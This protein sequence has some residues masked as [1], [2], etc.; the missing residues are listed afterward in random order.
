VAWNS[1]SVTG[2][3]CDG[4]APSLALPGYLRK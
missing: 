3:R 2:L 4:T 1:A